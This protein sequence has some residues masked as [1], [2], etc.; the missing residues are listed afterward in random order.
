MEPRP[1]WVQQEKPQQGQGQGA[2]CVAEVAE[3]GM[4]RDADAAGAVGVEVIGGFL[5]PYGHA[6]VGP[7]QPF[8]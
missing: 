6:H 1:G 7:G 5:W 4:L 8:E 3:D 2:I